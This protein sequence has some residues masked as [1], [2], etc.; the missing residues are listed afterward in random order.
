MDDDE[1]LRRFGLHPVPADLPE[2]RAVLHA[3]AQLRQDEQ[4]TELMRLSCLQLFNAGHLGDVLNIWHAKES[5]W[6]AHHAL[7]VRFLCGAGLEATKNHLAAEDSPSA[8]EALRYLTECEATGD[9]QNF[10]PA[11]HSRDW[12]DYYQP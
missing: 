11:R 7:D 5:S 9:F 3:Q 8:A 6:D 2:I 4:D 10:S 1:S 12:A